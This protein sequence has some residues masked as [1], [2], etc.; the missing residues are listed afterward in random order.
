MNKES[1]LDSVLELVSFYDILT[2]DLKEEINRLAD[3]L[4][5][6]AADNPNVEVIHSGSGF[7][8]LSLPH[9]E[10]RGWWNT[11]ADHMLVRTDVEILDCKAVVSVSEPS[12]STDIAEN[13]VPKTVY[14]H[15]GVHS[16]YV[17]L[18]SKRL[19]ITGENLDARAAPEYCLKNKEFIK[20]CK[21]MIP[22][23]KTLMMAL[24]EEDT[25]CI[26]GPSYSLPYT[27]GLNML[28]RD[29]VY[30]LKC[31]FWP[32]QAAEWRTRERLHSWPSSEMISNIVAHGCHIVPVGSHITDN[33]RDFEWRLSFSVAEMLLIQTLTK[34]QKLTYSILKAL[35]KSEMKLR[36]ITVFS[37]YHLK[38]A[39]L[40]FLELKGQALCQKDSCTLGQN[41]LELLEFLTDFYS[42]ETMPN[43]FVRTNNMIDHRSSKEILAVCNVLKEMKINFTQS[44]CQYIEG[45]QALPVFFDQSLTQIC[46]E[47]PKKLMQVC[48]YNFLLMALAGFLKSQKLNED[49]QSY[50]KVCHLLKQSVVLHTTLRECCEVAHLENISVGSITA[51][52]ILSIVEG[53]LATD[54]LK[55]TE[56]SAVVLAVFN[57]FLATHPSNLCNIGIPQNTREFYEYL[58]NPEFKETLFWAARQHEKYCDAIYDFVVQH[59]KDG[60]HFI[61]KDLEAQRVMKLLMVCLGKPTKQAAAV[62]GSMAQLDVSDKRFLIM[63][64]LASY[65]LHVHLESA[66]VVFQAAGYLMGKSVLSE[67]LNVIN[68]TPDKQTKLFAL[69][70]IL[71]KDELKVHLPKEE[72]DKLIQQKQELVPSTHFIS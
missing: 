49:K 59:W 38:T 32:S 8:G 30:S 64:V 29:F 23:S 20:S 33:L 67:I 72:V 71:S 54:K 15:D 45:N 34:D 55:V 50:S 62:T 70:L 14:M 47:N 17:F 21:S 44:L 9:V 22:L 52:F 61:S 40:W 2:Y 18:A 13:V 19:K 51:E 4:D 43:Y 31:K 48:K 37:S 68:G 24:V 57:V 11:D 25:L 41:I 7:E 36:E 35:I 1:V 16:G 58:A 26:C 5:K 12:V 53:F 3:D 63:R 69:E 39:L 66:Y 6:C 27:G 28:H 56:N 65:L 60:P 10:Q 42:K 46:A